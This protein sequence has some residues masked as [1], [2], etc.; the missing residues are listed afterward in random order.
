IV[1]NLSANRSAACFALQYANLAEDSN[2][3]KLSLQNP[4]L[5]GLARDSAFIRQQEAKWI[6]HPAT[7]LAAIKCAFQPIDENG[8]EK[9]V[10]EETD[11]PHLCRF[12][13]GGFKLLG[14]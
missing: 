9:T 7:D 11:Q 13:I 8:A 1:E 5:S 4:N 12:P 2:A 3:R 6:A 14:Q 10:M